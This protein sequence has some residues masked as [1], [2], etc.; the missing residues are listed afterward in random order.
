MNSQQEI[1]DDLLEDKKN[2]TSFQIFSNKNFKN[3]NI[4]ITL[5]EVLLLN[6]TNESREKALFFKEIKKEKGWNREI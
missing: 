2:P 4:H 6:Y 1:S 5:T 3:Q